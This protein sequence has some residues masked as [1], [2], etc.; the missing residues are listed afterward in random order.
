MSQPR[1]RP[2][3]TRRQRVNHQPDLQQVVLRG[4]EIADLQ[5]ELIGLF[6]SSMLNQR[7]SVVNH[8]NVETFQLRSDAVLFH[9]FQQPLN[10]LRRVHARTTAKIQ[11]AQ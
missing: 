10:G 7:I 4:G 2:P 1:Q 3:C 11:P 8:S 9:F 6:Q 5:V